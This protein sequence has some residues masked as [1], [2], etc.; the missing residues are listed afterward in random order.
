MS[1]KCLVK[2][3]DKETEPHQY[4]SEK[5]KGRVRCG[6]KLARPPQRQIEQARV[7]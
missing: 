1:D 3:A 5:T 4:N 2:N 7:Y 6:R